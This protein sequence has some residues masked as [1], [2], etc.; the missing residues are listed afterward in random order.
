IWDLLYDLSNRGITIFVTTHYMDEAERCTEVGFISEGKL[1]A[2]A[3]PRVLI[4]SFRV[5]LLELNIEPVMPALVELR[6]A[7]GV[8]GVSL[9]SGQ[10]RVYSG[11]PKQLLEQWKTRWPFPD[12]KLNGERWVEPDMEDVFTAYSQG[13]SAML[14]PDQNE[15]QSAAEDGRQLQRAARETA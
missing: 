13:Y 4:A 8:L 15:P 1:L 9:R 3:T 6:D 14:V 2:K 11:A 7:P 5:P 10:L 12:L